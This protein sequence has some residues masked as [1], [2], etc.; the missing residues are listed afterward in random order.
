MNWMVSEELQV[1][2]DPSGKGTPSLETSGLSIWNIS[3]EL[4][5]VNGVA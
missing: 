1:G 2:A 4:F 5:G 3:R